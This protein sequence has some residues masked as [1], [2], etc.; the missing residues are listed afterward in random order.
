[1]DVVDI[2]DSDEEEQAAEKPS[3]NETPT[4]EAA[5]VSSTTP[6]TEVRKNRP[7]P[8][9][10]KLKLGV[11]VEKE[12]LTE[13]K[14]QTKAESPAPDSDQNYRKQNKILTNLVDPC[15]KFLA[16]FNPEQSIRERRKMVRKTTGPQPTSYQKP[17][18]L[19]DDNGIHRATGLDACD[20]LD[21][22]C[23]GC[24]FPCPGCGSNKWYVFGFVCLKI[25]LKFQ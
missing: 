9:S 24:H 13:A 17:G 12:Q 16:D 7:G 14:E 18:T 10:M 4:T 15:S 19:Y 20:C 2:L 6:S 23:P 25:R 11:P 8:L 1:M 5:T 21:V 3:T 22:S